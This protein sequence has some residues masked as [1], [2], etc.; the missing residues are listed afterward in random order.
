VSFSPQYPLW[1]D[2]ASKRRWI[3]L[4]PGSSID[5]SHPDA[6]VFP[7][8]T[9]L[10]KEFA[11]GKA[12]ETRM[13]ERLADGTWRFAA[14]VW[15]Q[16]GSDAE[17][18]SIEGIP[19]LTL[20]AAPGGVYSVPSEM[21]C[22]ACHEGS[23]VPVLGFSAL[24]LAAN[25]DPGALHTQPVAADDLDL[26]KL[27]AR[28]LLCNLPTSLLDKAPGSDPPS[29]ATRSVLGYLH[30]NCGHCH[31]DPEASG[32]GVPVD[33]VLAQ[34][35]DRP[36]STTAVLQSLRGTTSRFRI[37]GE[38][39]HNKAELV[40]K[41]MASRDPNRQMPPLGT[42]VADA[43]ALSLIERWIGDELFPTDH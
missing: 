22:R 7:I 42:H 31:N 24:Q 1:S 37:S 5:A 30:A 11:F 14:Y 39:V 38:P 29:A 17:L 28:G 4:P 43:E 35:V 36:D 9:K 2:G 15:R 18:A 34:Y 21:D 12:V 23:A 25:R 16:D 40:L 19:A 13:I 6:W 41:R 27:V 10:W 33:L 26:P 20:T 8:G 3:Y 32:A